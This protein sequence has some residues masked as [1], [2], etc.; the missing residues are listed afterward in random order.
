MLLDR[1]HIEVQSVAELLWYIDVYPPPEIIVPPNQRKPVIG[2]D[3]AENQSIVLP[4]AGRPP[5]EVIAV[6]PP[7]PS[8][9]PVQHVPPSLFAVI[10]GINEYADPKV[11][12]LLGA[13]P[14]AD[15]VCDFLVSDLRVPKDR[16]VNL[17]N[18]EATREGILNV[19][20]DLV[21]NPNILSQDPLLIF[22]AGHGGE[23]N[24]PDGWQISND[25]NK[26]QMLIPHDF[27]ISG[28]DTL[29][30]HGVFD[31]TLSRLLTDIANNKS[32][33]VTVI[34]DSCHSGSGTRDDEWDETFATRSVRLPKEYKIPIRVLEEDSGERTSSIA[35]GYERGGL[36]SHVLLAACMQGQTAKERDHRGAFTS[37]LLE[38]LKEEGVDKLT[39]KDVIARIP[40]LPLQNPQ[41]EGVNQSRILFNAKVASPYRALF[42]I[43]P[44]SDCFI[45][46][47]GEAHGISKEA[48]FNV[49]SDRK[50]TQLLGT[51]KAD[52]PNP[53][54]TRCIVDGS[55]F[56]LVEPAFALQ[57]HVGEGQDIRLF[58]EANDAFLDLFVSLGKQM[59]RTDGN[60]RSFRLVNSVDENPD[61]AISA[62]DGFVRFHIME[63]VC[64]DKGLTEMPFY[65][66]PVHKTDDL[67]TI[68]RSAADFYW[69][70]HYTN[71]NPK[72]PILTQKV[73]LECFKLVYSG[74][75][76][77]DFEEILAPAQD[78]QNLNVDGMITIDVD[79]DV[80][81][82]YKI[83]NDSNVP[84]YAALFYFDFSDLSIASYYQPPVAKNK[85]DYSIPAH[86]CLTI[87]F[88]DSGTVP[89]TYFLRNNQEVDVG[90]LKLYLTTKYVDHSGIPQLSPFGRDRG[91]RAEPAKQR[92]LWDTLT[93]PMV[94]RRG[95]TFDRS[96]RSGGRLGTGL[97][98]YGEEFGASFGARF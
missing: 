48:E 52:A 43:K 6:P 36:R 55:P 97:G 88:G 76:T 13:V 95:S 98:G 80:P 91:N 84:L 67:L 17:R 38:L 63:Q 35:K 10:I 45:L 69:N 64:R 57:T 72:G 78:A 41:C 73:S 50:L 86:G 83:K 4:E 33:N 46:E 54:H 82:G 70:L 61:L 23:A 53:F 68:L 19:L 21:K 31:F 1:L 71:R 60:K 15:A 62:K 49:Y 87:G 3:F 40:D 16:I 11:N 12:N 32:D 34:F 75:Y 39:Y 66:T 51:V 22:Y 94:Q 25:G 42:N 18:Q 96:S 2:D 27:A 47:A 20:Q 59:Q 92:L 74:Q 44:S 90:F 26:I 79:E 77:D 89:Y 58:V 8:V 7:P 9:I 81:Y 5:E 37:Q 29:Q 14:D 24:A 85:V 30:G 65:R 28:S 93:I 56:S